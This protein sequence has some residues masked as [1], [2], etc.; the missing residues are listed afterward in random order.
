[1]KKKREYLIQNSETNLEMANKAL[2][3]FFFSFHISYYCIMEAVNI[4]MYKEI[5]Q[6]S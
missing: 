5:F 1:M 6:K 3:M 4:L 2:C